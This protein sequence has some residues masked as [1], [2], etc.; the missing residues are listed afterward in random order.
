M[1]NAVLVAVTVFL[2]R[3]LTIRRIGLLVQS[4]PLVAR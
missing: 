3:D 4:C 2:Q 1:L